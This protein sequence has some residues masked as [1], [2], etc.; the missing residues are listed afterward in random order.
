VS[1]VP[2]PPPGHVL[3]RLG[4]QV[5]RLGDR[6]A[7]ALRLPDRG[8]AS[9]LD[10]ALR[11]AAA[12]S[13][14]DVVAM[15]CLAQSGAGPAVTADLGASLVAG[16]LQGPLLLQARVVRRGRSLAVLAVD[17]GEVGAAEVSAALLGDHG[18]RPLPVADPVGPPVL[19]DAPAELSPATFGL[20]ANAAGGWLLEPGPAV[21]N[22]VGK[23]HGGVQAALALVTGVERRR[24]QE[25]SVLPGALDVELA[26]LRATDGPLLARPGSQDPGA[27]SVLLEEPAGGP[28]VAWAGIGFAGRLAA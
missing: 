27:L 25:P 5:G 18:P 7:G 28:P 17:L 13:A 12:V 22:R 23:L 19:P 24:P 20:R 14:L 16:A 3:A 15:R 26:Y 1:E 21:A 6:S 2:Y 8:P 9:P 10:L 11:A 4:L